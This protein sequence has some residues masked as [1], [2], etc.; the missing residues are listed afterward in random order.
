VFF[1]LILIA[2]I[3]WAAGSFIIISHIN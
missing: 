3:M 1:I 2:F